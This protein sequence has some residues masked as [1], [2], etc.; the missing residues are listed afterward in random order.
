MQLGECNE[1]KWLWVS[2]SATNYNNIDS[3]WCKYTYIDSQYEYNYTTANMKSE[4][5][6][7]FFAYYKTKTITNFKK[8]KREKT[9]GMVSRCT[10]LVIWLLP[11]IFVVLVSNSNSEVK[12]RCETCFGCITGF[13]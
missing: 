10:G 12:A 5:H 2:A 9:V 6:V 11:Q 13:P 4:N 3:I 7:N 8:V 1:K